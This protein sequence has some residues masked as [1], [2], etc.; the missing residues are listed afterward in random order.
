MSEGKMKQSRLDNLSYNVLCKFVKNVVE[1]P[2]QTP[3]YKVQDV[4]ILSDEK[5]GR[6]IKAIVGLDKGFDKIQV[7]E[8][9][10]GEYGLVRRVDKTHFRYEASYLNNNFSQGWIV[11]IA[12]TQKDVCKY[13][14][15]TRDLYD[16]IF[17]K[18]K[19]EEISEIE[20]KYELAKKNKYYALSKMMQVI[21]PSEDE[22]E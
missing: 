6:V 1:K 18:Q 8:L 7:L 22:C 19:Q 17:E 20:D 10:F 2:G 16:S 15:E 14:N 5:I 13:V 21:Q 12:T 4:I 11:N 9:Y 3:T